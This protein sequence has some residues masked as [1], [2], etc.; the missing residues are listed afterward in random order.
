MVHPGFASVLQESAGSST[1]P[2]NTCLLR[3]ALPAPTKGRDSP[4]VLQ[5]A[6][7]M[8][9]ATERAGGYKDI[10]Y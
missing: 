6:S 7:G 9:V 5:D 10:K 1:S 4:S 8:T 2:S 3:Q